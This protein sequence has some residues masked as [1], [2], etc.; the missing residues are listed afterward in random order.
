MLDKHWTEYLGRGRDRKVEGVL[1]RIEA[2]SVIIQDR[3]KGTGTRR[4]PEIPFEM[5][6]ATWDVNGLG[7]TWL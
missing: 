1:L 7:S 6:V 5:E 4:L 2:A 3:R